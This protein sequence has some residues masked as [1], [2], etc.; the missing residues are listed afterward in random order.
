MHYLI[1]C[2]SNIFKSLANSFF[3]TTDTQYCHN[4]VI[5][6]VGLRRQP[7][8]NSS[9]LFFDE[10]YVLRLAVSGLDLDDVTALWEVG[11]VEG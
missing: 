4:H 8:Y 2:F 6:G 7:R 11:D 1:A 10:F 3:V 5:F 9:W